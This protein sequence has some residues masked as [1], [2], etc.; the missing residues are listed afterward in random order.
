[1]YGAAFGK[2]NARNSF[3]LEV[4]R[5]AKGDK[6]GPVAFVHKLRLAPHSLPSLRIFGFCLRMATDEPF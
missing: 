5:L 4:G 6:F 2:E 3:R 1:M